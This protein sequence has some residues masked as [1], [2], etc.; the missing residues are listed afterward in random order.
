MTERIEKLVKRMETQKTFPICVEKA[1]IFTETFKKNENRPLIVKRA[2]AEAAYMDQRTLLIDKDQLLAYNMAEKLFGIE[3][4]PISAGWPEEDLQT[5]LEAGIMTLNEEDHKTLRSLDEYWMNTYRSFDEMRTH[6]LSGNEELF[7]YMKHGFQTPPWSPVQFVGSA[8]DAWGGKAPTILL[9]PDYAMHLSTGFAKYVADAKA[10]LADMKFGNDPKALEKIDYLEA[11]IIVFE[12]MIRMG[13]RYAELADKTAA[14]ETD[15]KVKKELEELAVVLHQVPEFPARTFREALQAFIF[16]WNLLA[17]GSTGLGR[18]DQYLYPFYKADIEAGR[19]TPDEALE[20]LC[21]MRL[22]LMEYNF[23]MGG[24]FQREKWAGMARWNNIILGGCDPET[25][26]DA[27]NELSYLIL[28]S[29]NIVRSTHPTMTIR[30]GKDTPAALLRKG[31]DVVSTGIGMPAFIS[32]IE[33]MKYLT[34]ER[35]VDEKMAREFAISGCLDITIPGK[36]RGDHIAMFVVPMVL[37]CAMNNGKSLKNPAQLGPETGFFRDFKTYDELYD[38]FMAQMDCCLRKFRDVSTMKLLLDQRLYQDAVS[39]GFFPDSLE[40]C[41]DILCRRVPF[42]NDVAFNVVGMVNTIN[43]LAAVKKLCYED[44][45]CTPA[46]LHDALIKN[47]E[48]YEELRRACLD[49]PKYGNNIPYVDDLGAKLWEDIRDLTKKYKTIFG[50]SMILSGISISSHAPG[51]RSTS[52][53]P[54]GRMDG[55]TL[56]DGSA[57]PVQGTDK[58]GPLAVLQ[59]AMKMSK[60]WSV[61]LLNMKFT[62][63]ALKSGEDRDK[64]ASMIKVFMTNGGKHVQFNVVDRATLQDAKDHPDKHPNLIVRVAGYSAYYV[65]L[66]ERIQNEVM[67]RT[68]HTL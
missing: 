11:T 15:P 52:A 54:D 12:A 41:Q 9:T 40:A 31:V 17:T 35:G 20:L 26:K 19:I 37:E 16:Y 13:R 28:E 53:T 42:E 55:E 62:P 65:Q 46:E 51:G 60:G 49:A 56:A 30:V 3:L 38:A 61:N 43:S 64:L 5:I 8:G 23:C 27:T 50:E 67:E 66:T 2:L 44:K 47:W 25:G 39:S 22:K 59:S 6:Y 1:R 4:R 68:A 32:E 18:M 10:K 48:G 58:S 14:E 29:A 33:Y 36:A 34:D 21:C 57:S 24:K 45:V 7:T 63:A